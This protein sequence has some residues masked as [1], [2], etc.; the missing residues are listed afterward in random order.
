M[1]ASN[2]VP[3]PFLSFSLSL[4]L[5]LSPLFN[6]MASAQLSFPLLSL[7]IGATSDYRAC[8][9]RPIVII[10]L[11]HC[12]KVRWEEQRGWW[13]E[14]SSSLMASQ[15]PPLSSYASQILECLKS[16]KRLLEKQH[17]I[18][19]LLLYFEWVSNSYYFRALK[20]PLVAHGA[21]KMKLCFLLRVFI[22]RFPNGPEVISVVNPAQGQL[23]L[24]PPL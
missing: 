23:Q 24:L 8:P 10:I 21:R 13:H 9:Q 2:R 17:G 1:D 19:V 22:C 6:W 11:T 5:S 7:H 18:I 16:M 20:G 12:E 14:Q 4:S 3:F 15:I